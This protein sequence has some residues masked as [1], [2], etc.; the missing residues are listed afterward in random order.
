MIS[1]FQKLTLSALDGLTEKEREVAIE[2]L[3]QYASQ[4]NSEL[5]GELKYAD[6]E[7]IPVDVH[8]FLHDKK[9]L[10]RGLYDNEG[11]F[12]LF[13]YWEQKL[14]E[15]FPDNLTTA[16]NTVVLTGAIGIGKAQPLSSLVLTENGFKQM[17]KLTLTDK[18]FGND[19]K[20]HNILGIFPQGK[21]K[22]C[23]VS[24]SDK[25]STLCCDEH[26]WTVY[27]IDTQ[28]WTTI[29]TK[30]FLNGSKNLNRGYGHRY[31]IPI[32][33]PIEFKQ[34]TELKIDP[35]ILGILIGD[36]SLTIGSTNFA[37]A[38]QEIVDSVKNALLP[39]YEIRKLQ[40]KYSYSICKIKNNT[41][42]D[43]VTK[44][45]SP[46]PN[47]YTK[48]IKDL[49][50][51]TK[52][53]FKHIPKNYLYADI[54]DRIALLQG[55]MDT[56]GHITKDGSV[57]T[58]ATV[59][60]QLAEDFKFLVQ[61]LGGICH[62]RLKN[63]QYKKSNGDIVKCKPCYS[64]GIKL[65]K[66][67]KP[68]RLSRKV[69]RLSE[70]AL[71]PFRYITKIEYVGEDDCQCIYIDSKEH[72]Y[73]TNDFIVTHNTLFADIC[74]LYMLYR[75]LC[76]KDPYTYFGMQLIDKI[77]I[78]FMNITIEN[79]K[80]VALDKMNQLLLSSEWFMSHGTMSGTTNLIYR[81]EKHIELIAAS[82][83]NQIVGRALF[84]SFE[85]EANFSLF[86]NPEKQKKKM[87]KIITQI[88]ARMRSRF[89]RGTYLPTL[90]IIASSKD[91]EQSFLESYIDDKIKN[92]SK[93]TLIVDEAQ[94]V[95]DPRKDSPIKFYVAIGNKFLANELLPLD[96]KE[97]ELEVY[98]SKSYELVQVPIGYL[99]V[100]Q[101]NLDEAICSIIGI[102]TASSLKYISGDKLN[103]IK[104]SNYTNLFM[105]DSIK[106]GNAPDDYLQ[107]ANFF[108]LSLVTPEDLS[109]PLFIHL[110][111]STSGDKTG[112]AGVWI[113][114]R[115]KN[116]K[117][118]PPSD[119][120]T[121]LALESASYNELA[122]D[123]HYKVAF[124]V[125]VEAP[126]GAQVSFAKTRNFIR[127]LREQGFAIKCVSMDTFQSASTKQDLTNDGFKT[128][129]VSVDRVTKDANG[130]PLCLPYHY[131]K[132]AIYERRL[133]L[134][135]K[136][137]LLTNELV[138]LERKSDGH[139][140]HTKEGIN[141]LSG[142]TKISLVDG[143]ELT[144]IELV[145]EYNNGKENYVYTINE[146]TLKI[147]P[148][149]I[150]KAYKSGTTSN[151]L[152]I[153]LDNDEYII[154]T[155]EHK[156]ML[157]NGSY[158]MAKDLVEN[159][160]LMPLYRKYPTEVVSMKNYRLYYEPVE[161][162]WHYE[163]RQFASEVLDEKYLVHHKNCNKDDNTP[164]NLIWCSKQAH[165]QIHNSLQTGAQSLESNEKRKKS[166]V[167]WH[168]VNKNNTNYI[169][170]H[171][172]LSKNSNLSEEEID[173]FLDNRLKKQEKE[174]ERINNINELFNINYK[175][176]SA[177]EKIKYNDDY[178]NYVKGNKIG[179][180]KKA[181]DKHLLIKEQIANTFN[182]DS[183]DLSDEEYQ[184]YAI[185]LARLQDPSY[186]E[187]VTK[188]VIENRKA[189]KYKNAKL[190]LQK[191]NLQCKEL[192]KLFPVIDKD[193]FKE[194]F[195]FDYNT[196]DRNHRGVWT[197]RY[198]QKMYD[199]KNHKVIKIENI[200][201]LMPVYDLYIKDN[202]N[203]AL[204]S[205]VFVHNSKDQADAVCGA[206]W[207]ASKFSDEY[208]YA[209]GDNLAATLDANDED[210]DNYKKQ[211]IILD[212]EQELLKI[213]NE[214]EKVQKLEN[215]KRNE[216]W[217]DYKDILDGIIVV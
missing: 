215:K 30:Q 72:L 112:I 22:I 183:D 4:G 40:E 157:R 194:L 87:M 110:D 78:S 200:T 176:L 124:S 55:L 120:N 149:P 174:M 117:A 186:Q 42:Y 131:F 111:M 217:E 197:N 100:F 119:G 18:V 8:T 159:D 58:F 101:Q 211:Q 39:N 54:D 203:F 172:H 48:Y 17:G 46:T 49:K 153:T 123:L 143:R 79:A 188:A 76:L 161:D 77:S 51:N 182:I 113:T 83:N 50:L 145:N 152:K 70:K 80:G 108:D 185:K 137:D 82:S 62:I 204:T 178:H 2:I 102:A 125:S 67:I 24:F 5:L 37:S 192:K 171:N 156:F 114:G 195:N 201:K 95:V 150:L 45:H 41:V 3:K 57:L 98:R 189:G 196:L 209:Y 71:E 177:S 74:L 16:Y 103:K 175:T 208:S 25:T 126:K 212:F 35:Y 53:E 66:N 207:S 116:V 202:H 96:I 140:D 19:G 14:N 130:K 47:L 9:Y 27:N 73:L 34:D 26:L 65:P 144:M 122:N 129:I 93:T 97:D 68:F 107:Y 81:P 1:D 166:L 206:I 28:K 127:W 158:C 141:C 11:R 118:L 85:D 180:R 84:A 38:D 154:C 31:K 88:D 69:N 61:S 105:K 187:K 44:I 133:V 13:P 147:E 89:L 139:V 216:E 164:T 165:I 104:T 148:K 21:K 146:N 193:K 205:G 23:K 32:T 20:L 136:C 56:D 99:D 91:T 90:N 106:V 115:E 121:S 169:L 86:N 167:K 109:K 190:A 160:S 134:Y 36:G 142:D 155:P 163:H 214:F 210:N 135:Q 191:Y 75:L 151:L 63:T 132:T 138:G 29:E 168:R 213:G 52:A 179:S 10:G 94:W 6:Y 92:E 170:S 33:S 59:S 12:T 198:R 60:P 43:P 199:L 181:Q 162:K 128:E 15:L 7:E 173:E 64:I 184:S